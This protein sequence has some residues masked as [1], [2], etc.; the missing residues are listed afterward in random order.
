LYTGCKISMGKHHCLRGKFP[1]LGHDL[2]AEE[3]SSHTRENKNYSK[4]SPACKMIDS[5]SCTADPG[6]LICPH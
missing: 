4:S 1:Y 2:T 6:L 5:L 3:F